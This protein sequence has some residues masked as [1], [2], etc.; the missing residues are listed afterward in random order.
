MPISV[1]VALLERFAYLFGETQLYQHLEGIL[2]GITN[3]HNQTL[4]TED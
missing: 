3:N 1:Y 4:L 2:N